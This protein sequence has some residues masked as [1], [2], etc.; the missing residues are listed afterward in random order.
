MTAKV[1]KTAMR[2]GMLSM[3]GGFDALLRELQGGRVE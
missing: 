2:R 3:K 1:K